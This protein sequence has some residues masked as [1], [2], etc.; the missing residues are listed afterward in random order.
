[1]TNLVKIIFKFI[2]QI[3]SCYQIYVMNNE[4]QFRTKNKGYNSKLGGKFHPV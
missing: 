4:L 2:I 1:M 3:A